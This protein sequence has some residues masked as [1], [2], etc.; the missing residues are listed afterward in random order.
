M[1]KRK[2]PAII[3]PFLG[4]IFHILISELISGSNL[5]TNSVGIKKNR[6]HFRDPAPQVETMWVVNLH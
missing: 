4:S 2:K 3:L 6:G 1:K 5:K